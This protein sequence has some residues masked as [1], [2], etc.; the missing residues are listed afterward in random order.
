L[1]RKHYSGR[2]FHDELYLEAIR[3]QIQPN[4]R[5]LDAGCGRYLKFCKA[6]APVAGDVVG[7]DLENDLETRND[8]SPFGVRGDLDHLPFPSDHFD[9]VI[10]RSVIEH[11]SDPPQVFREFFR[12]LR[13]GGRVVLITPNKYDYVSIAACLTP[14]RFH[15]KLVSKIFGVREDDVFPTFYRANTRTSIDR[16]LRGAGF[17][18]RELDTINHYPAYLMFSP[19]L[20]RVGVVYERLISLRIFRSLRASI[21]C[22]YEKPGCA[23]P[24]G[25]EMTAAGNRGPAMREE[26]LR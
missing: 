2:K 26:L 20:F 21:L 14:Y 16:A 5:V 15:Q 8:R 23:E 17:A 12:V 7:V 13:P 6:L 3:K 25:V 18:V 1:F 4:H 22:V 24:K 9:L 19:M 10:S 11:L